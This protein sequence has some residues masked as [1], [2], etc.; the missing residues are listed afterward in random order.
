MA[1]R[2]AALLRPGAISLS[3]LDL[4][5]DSFTVA[6]GTNSDILMTGWTVLSETYD[7]KHGWTGTQ[8]FNFPDGYMLRSGG[9]LT[10][11]SGRTTGKDIFSRFRA[12]VRE[13]AASAPYGVW[14][15]REREQEGMAHYLWTGRY[16]WNNDGD[17][18]ALRDADGNVLDRLVASAVELQIDSPLGTETQATAVRISMLELQNERVKVVNSGDAAVDLSGWILKSLTGSQQFAFPEGFLLGQDEVVNVVSGPG[19]EDTEYSPLPE[20]EQER[21]LVWGKRNM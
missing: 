20:E 5:G 16:M 6:N 11:W 1:V 15:D 10:V 4:L 19:W 17:A 18:A 9:K 14:I 12:Q 13:G 3:S 21:Q 8:T 2:W 7:S